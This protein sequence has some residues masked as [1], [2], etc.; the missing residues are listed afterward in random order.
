MIERKGAN[1]WKLQRLSQLI[2]K[3]GVFF[4]HKKAGYSTKTRLTVLSKIAIVL[5]LASLILIS[6]TSLFQI[7]SFI[8][9]VNSALNI[10]KLA[11][12]KGSTSIANKSKG[13][14]STVSSNLIANENLQTAINVQDD[15][16]VGSDD[17]KAKITSTETYFEFKD[18]AGTLYSVKGV[19]KQAQAQN[20]DGV[21][22][23]VSTERSEVANLKSSTPLDTSTVQP[24]TVSTPLDKPLETPV[25]Q[26]ETILT[27]QEK[28]AEAIDREKITYD[29]VVAGVDI[30]QKVYDRKIKEA[31]IVENKEAPTKFQF[32]L[33]SSDNLEVKQQGNQ[34]AFT[35]KGEEKSLVNIEKA[36]ANDQTG[37]EF[38]FKYSL[39]GNTLIL[40]PDSDLS[41]VVY[42]LVIDPSY[43]VIASVGTADYNNQR[44]LARD[45]S[46]NIYAT[47]HR[48]DGSA[49]AIFVSKSTDGGQ[50][51][52]ETEISEGD[53]YLQHYPTIAIDGNNYIHVAWAG[54][55][56]EAYGISDQIR[57][58]KFTTSWQAIVNITGANYAQT[59]PSLAIDA[60]NYVNLVWAG[61]DA[62]HAQDQI[63][64]K[65]YTTSWQATVGLTNEA[66]Y[67]QNPS[68]AVDSSNYLHVVWKGRNAASTATYQIRYINYTSSWQSIQELTTD[69][70]Y[71]QGAPSIA[72]SNDNYLHVVFNGLSASFTT[73][74]QIR[75]L[76][77]TSSWQAVVNW[78]HDVSYDQ[79][80]PT[81]STD[82]SN[83]HVVW[84]SE[85]TNSG[86]FLYTRYREYTS[87]W[88]AIATLLDGGSRTRPSLMFATYPI[89]SGQRVSR[90]GVGYTLLYAASSTLTIFNSADLSWTDPPTTTVPDP[91]TAVSASAGNTEA[92][93]SFTAPANNGGADIT[94]YTVTST[95]GSFTGTGA[96]SPITVTGLTN[97]TSYT[98]T[99]HATNSVGNSAESSAS[100]AII[101]ATVPDPP[102]AVSASA[103][104]TQA[105][106]SF[107]APANNGG[108]DITGY[109]VTSTPG[110]LTGTGATSPITVIG[111]TNGTEYTFTVH[112]TNSVGNS[113]ESTASAAVTPAVPIVAPTVTT[114]AVSGV[115]QTSATLNGTVTATGGA[116]AT[117]RGFKYS[118]VGEQ[119]DFATYDSGDYGVVAYTKLLG[120]LTA[121][122]TYHIRAYAT[123]SAGTGYGAWVS[124]GT[125]DP[126]V[127]LTGTTSIS[128]NWASTDITATLS[129]ASSKSVTV[130]LAFSGTAT[131]LSDY[132][133]S[134]TSIV[135][136]AGQ[137]TGSVS[138]TGVDDILDES[139]ETVVVDIDSV[140]NGTESS[141]QQAT[142][143][144]IDNDSP[145]TIAFS[146][147][148]SSG[149]EATTSVNIPVSLSTASGLDTSVG[150]SVTGGTATGGGVDYTLASGTATITAGST[151]TNIA[152]TII[153]DTLDENDETIIV[154]LATPTNATLGATTEFTYT[155]N[156]NDA[157]P[158][159]SFDSASGSNAESTT[160]VS[161]PL[162]ISTASGLEAS[163]P[164]TVSGTATGG[165]VDYT[166]ASGTATI[167]AG[168]TTTNIN[169][170]II[171]DTLDENNESVIVTFGSPTNATA[172]A[173]TVYT[174]TITDDDS[175]PTI[176]FSSA[177]SS[178]AE[179]S[180]S[181]NI[182]VSLSTA[183]SLD[184]SVGYSVTSGTA[185]GGGVDYTLASGTA[186][187]TAGSASTDIA[188]TI[189]NDTLDEN[190]E[191]IIVTLASPTNSTL[192]ATTEHTYTINDNDSPPTTGFS[193]TSAAGPE[194]TASLNIGVSLSEVSGLNTSVNYAVT[195]GTATG[196]GVDYTLA[197]GTAT[198]TAGS[199]STNIAL[200]I[201][202]DILDEN[203]ETIIVTLASPTNSTL[204]AETEFTYTINDNDN[205]PTIG[206]TSASSSGA[207]SLTSVNIPISLSSTSGL[208]TSV[209]YAVTGGTATGGGADYTLASG[210][211]TITAG[212]TSTNIVVTVANDT[213]DETDETIVATISD[214]TNATLGATT[215]HTY[216]ILDNDD[217]PTIDFALSADSGL[218]SSTSVVFQIRLSV[219]SS[220]DTSVAYAVTGGTA[221]GGGA[222]YTLASG[223]ATIAAGSTSTNIALAIVNDTDVESDETVMIALSDPINTTLGSNAQL[224]YTIVNNDSLAAAVSSDA[225]SSA[226]ATAQRSTVSSTGSGTLNL[227]P[228]VGT[229]QPDV[230]ATSQPVTQP[231]LESY[232][233]SLLVTNSN[234]QPIA[235]ARV[236]LHSDVQVSYSDENGYAY[237]KNVDPGEH[238]VLV[239]YANYSGEKTITAGGDKEK[240]EVKIT[241]EPNK[242]KSYQWLFVGVGSGVA[243]V[244]VIGAI[245]FLVKKKH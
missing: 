155:I 135:I 15:K 47:Y 46:G 143:T 149:S 17:F 117:I 63:W 84:Y 38:A 94:G 196:G 101:P 228:T 105:T 224:T 80:Y 131:N 24:E 42:P 106:I 177:S 214:P 231:S 193:L 90:P 197:S 199:T 122:T 7:S 76:K 45:G 130:N 192:G 238:K 96:T 30:E 230:Q 65:Q 113:S 21:V 232:N 74:N 60:N 72:I 16:L 48:N 137:T 54:R 162:S 160:T 212:Q 157:T 147:A 111:L 172:G 112:A 202:N 12:V 126:T 216:T 236:E 189:I 140:T 61:T 120:S 79:Y 159:I 86:G 190:N 148:S 49:D 115:D 108:A 240:V 245:L 19:L 8:T 55:V 77:Y 33:T 68:I 10:H 166:L 23:G 218:E 56:T 156:D 213:L 136:T 207:E 183:S 215:E 51:W 50:N 139:N 138:I 144:L 185:T 62:T 25:V 78:T 64:Y 198:I 58:R 169:L 134:A 83:I 71:N 114:E 206:L 205:P 132:A 36:F 57:Y 70:G 145:P 164:Y 168:S 163:V 208:N 22:K 184:V 127:A 9:T 179:S 233:L 242:K 129:N 95:P 181:V 171:N 103:G 14:I 191:T 99:V 158:T 209:A 153:N 152:V 133:S 243:L 75:Y 109:T 93:V 239:T 97:G 201:V 11:S 234:G 26:Q 87:S 4:V 89:T 227:S 82:A 176:A 43:T 32:E 146:S 219:A 100:T 92:T 118:S 167:I 27:P 34:I 81:V 110:S 203:N 102:T 222:D 229:S 13:T 195:G 5:V 150:Y 104:N 39:S 67:Q 44:K 125:N 91:P 161:I 154:T 178:G 52:V 59:A 116:N 204:G 40:E 20:N 88:Q 170:T 187:I 235:G 18:E 124:F 175:P 241:L 211:A 244:L 200:A 53:G 220:K 142:V 210:T 237:F 69:N 1:W 188:V 31:L 6:S 226:T 151:S 35:K 29:N 141:S 73:V 121:G 37:K 194:S 173:N 186:T 128:E 165:G 180:T 41:E 221:T 223:T 98:F 3:L 217:P 28:P 107:T 66:R 2:D 119:D 85:D 174:Y 182:P 225:T 123:N